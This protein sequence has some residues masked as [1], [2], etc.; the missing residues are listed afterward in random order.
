MPPF[1]QVIGAVPYFFS[2]FCPNLGPN[3]L[4]ANSYHKPFGYKDGQIM[5]D[6]QCNGWLF[7]IAPTG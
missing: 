4:S 1:G 5:L 3:K 2:G 7:G 6:P